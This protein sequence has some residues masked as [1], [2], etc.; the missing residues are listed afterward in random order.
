M[1][2]NWSYRLVKMINEHGCYYTV[3]EVYYQHGEP[4][5]LT[6]DEIS[7]GGEDITEFKESLEM[8]L[9]DITRPILVYDMDTNKFVGE[10]PNPLQG[11]E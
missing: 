7:P 11:Q 4:W 5:M 3:H 9:H 8:Y 1:S 2:D 10:E 6:E